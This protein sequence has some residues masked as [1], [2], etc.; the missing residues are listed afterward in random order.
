MLGGITINLMVKVSSEEK[1]KC[2][3]TFTGTIPEKVI[4]TK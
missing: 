2:K 3:M 4:E 1:V